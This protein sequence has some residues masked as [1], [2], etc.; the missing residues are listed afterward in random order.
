MRKWMTI[1]IVL[2]IGSV[3]WLPGSAEARGKSKGDVCKKADQTLARTGV[4]DSDGDGLSDCRESRILSTD[5][6]NPDTDDDGL[7]DGDDFGKSCNPTDDDTDDDGTTDGEDPT[8]VITQK[9]VALL[10]T[11]TCPVDA[12]V[13][14]PT[15]AVPGSIGALGT[16]IVLTPDTHFWGIT[17]AD[18][19][20]QAALG[21]GNLLVE[22][23]VLENTLH[24]LNAT[25]VALERGCRR[26]DHHHGGW[27]GHDEN[28]DDQGQDD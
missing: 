10:D 2:L 6:Q 18:L 1:A 27:W 26:P 16:T 9:L 25:S 21:E 28:D 23:R 17:C 7:D 24:E 8:P 20:T 15:P 14:P 5:P 4:G 3:L 13:D 19:A 11:L 12:V 22:V